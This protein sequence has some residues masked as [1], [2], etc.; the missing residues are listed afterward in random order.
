MTDDIKKFV[1]PPPLELKHLIWILDWALEHCAESIEKA[2]LD[3]TRHI[4]NQEEWACT[5]WG[6]KERTQQLV[7]L[8]SVLVERR[9]IYAWLVGAKEQATNASAG[10]FARDIAA[11][12]MARKQ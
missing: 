2:E 9:K 12:F 1:A 3:R 4:A 6:Y 10:E 7:Q 5:R 11:M 8:D